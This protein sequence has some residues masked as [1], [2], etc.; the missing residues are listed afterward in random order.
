MENSLQ[1][2]RLSELEERIEKGLQ[3]FIDVGNC[4]LEV[5][6]KR[7]YREKG[8]SRFED[9]C[10][11][12]WGWSKTHANRNIAAAKTAE[13]LT[14]MGAIQ[15]ERQAR[16]FAPLVK[17]D[18][19]EAVETWRQLKDTYGDN[20]TSN[21]IK[22]AVTEKLK[23]TQP[24]GDPE[25]KVVAGVV[26]IETEELEWTESEKQR[27]AKA[28]KGETVTC[29][30][31]KDIALVDWAKEEGLFVRID[32]ATDW[33]NPFEIPG[34]GT[35]QEVCESYKIYFSLKKSLHGKISNL[36]GKVLGCHCYP[37]QCHGDYLK[38]VAENEG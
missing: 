11:E 16:E 25:K 10:R 36:N 21:K 26:E 8:Y 18:E 6:D 30:I 5:R 14:P 29:N 33:G 13:I 7:L 1:V 22:E 20:I 27:R 19:E 3:T 17:K 15:T 28:E 23:P 24:I 4:L 32:R 37:E 2:T 12:E 9:Y 34:D 31:Y 35:R 38:E